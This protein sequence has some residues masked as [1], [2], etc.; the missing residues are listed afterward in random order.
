[1][2]QNAAVMQPWES[3]SQAKGKKM[4]PQT[5]LSQAR[6][7]VGKAGRKGGGVGLAARG[8]VE[9]LGCRGYSETMLTT[10]VH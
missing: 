2:E 4:D 8:L 10:A 3:H 9:A 7:G 1:M 5:R 6:G